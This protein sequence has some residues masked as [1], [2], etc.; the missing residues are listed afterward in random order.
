MVTSEA[1]SYD[2]WR[3]PAPNGA[4][5]LW[6]T[7]YKEMGPYGP[8]AVDGKVIWFSSQGSSESGIYRYSEARGLEVVA[9][10]SDRLMW[11]AGPCA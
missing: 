6:S 4:I 2:L 9:R 1:D 10:F 8:V 5:K 11:V 7:P 3:V